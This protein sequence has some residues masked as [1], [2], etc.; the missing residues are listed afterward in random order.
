LSITSPLS[1][2]DEVNDT[3]PALDT[4][5]PR[6]RSGSAVD[7]LPPPA[8]SSVAPSDTIVYAAPPLA[9]PSD[10]FS[11]IFSV[12]LLTVVEPLYELVVAGESVRVLV[13]DVSLVMLPVPVIAPDNVW[14]VDDEYLNDP[15]L[16]MV[17]E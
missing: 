2:A 16:A 17:A 10:E 6:I 1:V 13:F 9:S 4:P 11:V 3:A 14:L 15:S 12:P 5:V 8:T 7:T